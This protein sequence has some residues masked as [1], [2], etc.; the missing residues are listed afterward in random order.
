MAVDK[1][2][3]L[4]PDLGANAAAFMTLSQI[5]GRWAAVRQAGDAKRLRD[6]QTSVEEARETN[7]TRPR[8]NPLAVG[9]AL[10]R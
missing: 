9:G 7:R 6:A 5:T 4:P 1:N 8:A 2:T 3:G 10:D